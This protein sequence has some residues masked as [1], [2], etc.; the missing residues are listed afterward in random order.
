MG[1]EGAFGALASAASVAFQGRERSEAPP[2]PHVL[3]HWEPPRR[4]DS[5]EGPQRERSGSEE[6]RSVN[7]ARASPGSEG[8]QRERSGSEEERSDSSPASEGPERERSG[9][10]D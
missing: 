2:Y 1:T 6:E 3:A 10:E 5:D 9:S 7:E 4:S 8:P